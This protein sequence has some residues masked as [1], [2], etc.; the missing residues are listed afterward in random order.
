L[1]L[2]LVDTQFVTL[3]CGA[4]PEGRDSKSL[5]SHPAA[6]DKDMIR[7]IYSSLCGALMFVAALIPVV[8]LFTDRALF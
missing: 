3:T 6:G 2:T 5:I 8:I 4:N 7:T 1:R